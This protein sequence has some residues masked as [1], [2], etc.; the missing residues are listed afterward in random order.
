MAIIISIIIFSSRNKGK[1]FQKIICTTHPSTWQYPLINYIDRKGCHGRFLCQVFVVFGLIL[2]GAGR[3]CAWWQSWCK[4]AGEFTVGLHRFYFCSIWANP[5][6]ICTWFLKN[7]SGKIK[8]VKMDFQSIL[9]L[10]FTACVSCKNQFRNQFLQA[11][12]PVHRNWFLQLDFF[13]NHLHTD[14]QR[15]RFFAFII[16]FVAL[17]SD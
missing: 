15:E 2:A 4:E 14:Q 3:P 12:N 10:I 5:L 8:F 11:K 7:Q 13:L 16:S 1:L 6:L 9:N 17:A